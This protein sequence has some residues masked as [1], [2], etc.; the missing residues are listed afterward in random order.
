M[1]SICY[2]RYLEQWRLPLQFRANHTF[3]EGKRS[4]GPKRM[5]L[6]SPVRKRDNQRSSTSKDLCSNCELLGP[7]PVPMRPMWF[8]CHPS[9]LRASI[10]KLFLIIRNRPQDHW[11][12]PFLIH[13]RVKPAIVLHTVLVVL[14]VIQYVARASQVVE[15]LSWRKDTA[16]ATKPTLTF[17]SKRPLLQSVISSVHHELDRRWKK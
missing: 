7:R 16:W 12:N 9:C 2:R 14:Y 17:F 1:P 11:K 10:L 4:L 13:A 5:P 8:P 15:A 3:K 6:D